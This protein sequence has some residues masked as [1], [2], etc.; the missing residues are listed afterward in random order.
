MSYVTDIQYLSY[1]DIFYLFTLRVE[2]Y[3]CIRLY[4][5]EHT[6]WVGLLCMSNRLVTETAT[7]QHTTLTNDIYLWSSGIRTRIPI[8]RTVAQPPGS[9]YFQYPTKKVFFRYCR[10]QHL[11]YS[12]VRWAA[13]FK[14]KQFISSSDRVVVIINLGFI[15]ANF[16]Y[17]IRRLKT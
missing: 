14:S 4:S 17:N 11:S 3:C 1:S 15:M 8:K 7:W 5:M 12:Y 16:I 9:A 6:R 13:G 2:S 10:Y